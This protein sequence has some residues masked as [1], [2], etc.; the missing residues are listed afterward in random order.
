[1]QEPYIALH[2]GFKKYK[3]SRSI[4]HGLLPSNCLCKLWWLGHIKWTWEVCDH[5]RWP[6]LHSP[7]QPC[8]SPQRMA[9]SVCCHCLLFY[10]LEVHL[11]WCSTCLNSDPNPQ[12]HSKSIW[13][14][15]LTVTSFVIIFF[16]VPSPFS[17]IQLCSLC[18]PRP[19][20]IL[21]AM[22]FIV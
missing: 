5:S 9:F 3:R 11:P 6:H 8:W 21:P 20:S 7:E 16:L 15:S 4:A 22:E 19:K 17:H 1:M 12:V 10:R 2:E 13:Q 14:T 18:F